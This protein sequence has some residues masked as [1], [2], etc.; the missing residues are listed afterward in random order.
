MWLIAPGF[1]IVMVVLGFTLL[2]YALDEIFN[3]R[4]RKR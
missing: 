4:L 1:A 3:P 2:G